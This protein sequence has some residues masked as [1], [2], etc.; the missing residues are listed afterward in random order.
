M[1]KVLKVLEKIFI[2]VSIIIL[3]WIGISFINV[4]CHN[5]ESNPQYFD[6]NF[7]VIH[8]RR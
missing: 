2:I 3:A 5:L 6:W 7:F 4:I 1:K 8:F